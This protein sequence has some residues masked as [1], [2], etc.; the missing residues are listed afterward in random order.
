MSSHNR[1]ISNVESYILIVAVS[2][3]ERNIGS[4]WLSV[5]SSLPN[6]AKSEFNISILYLILI[7]KLIFL[8]WPSVKSVFWILKFATRWNL[9]YSSPCVN[10]RLQGGCSKTIVLT[11][12]YHVF[13]FLWNKIYDSQL[14]EDFFDCQRTQ[15]QFQVFWLHNKVPN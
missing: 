7:P 10:V 15:L 12:V 8:L 11:A 6:G 14:S 3:N 4:L 9:T 13:G 5:F 2:P 1:A